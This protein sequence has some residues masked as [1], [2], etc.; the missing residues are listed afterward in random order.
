[1]LAQQHERGHPAVAFALDPQE[2]IRVDRLAAEDGVRFVLGAAELR[3]VDARDAPACDEARELGRRIGTRDHDD[4]DP[5]GHF[6][7]SLREGGALLGRRV[8]FVEVVE[9]D[10]ARQWQCREEIAEEAANEAREVLLRLRRELRQR[11]RRLA[12]EL[13]RGDAQV[14]QERR[15]VGVAGVVLVPEVTPVARLEIARD[16]R[17]LAGAR[18]AASQ[19]IG[20]VAASSSSAKRRG[21]GSASYSLGR[22]SLARGGRAATSRRDG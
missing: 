9:D 4:R 22:V 1:M 8:G 18:R 10:D 19:T 3:F 13:L 21:R 14:M 6:F 12:G 16:E 17:G 11:R 20:R 15:S 2:L 7:Q 5:L